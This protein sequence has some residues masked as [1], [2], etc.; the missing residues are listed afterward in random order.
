MARIT[1]GILGGFS[2]KVGTI[3]GANWRG[4]DIIRSTPKPSSRPPSEKQLLQQ[5]KFKLVISFLQPIKN[6]Q[7]RYFGSG[8]G[9]KSR[10]N[11]ATSYTLNEA[12]QVTADIPSLLYNKILITKGDLAGFQNPSAVPQ[13]GQVLTLSWEDNSIQGNAKATD[14]ANAVCYCEELGTFEIFEMLTD[15][16]SMTAN[17]TLAPYYSGKEIHVWMYFNNLEES[18]ACNSPYLGMFTVL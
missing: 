18:F 4:Q 15:R 17:I 14:P 1:K 10:V 9:S 12:V 11:M 3:V 7:N 16:S 5:N 2:G 6:I 13:S 8:S